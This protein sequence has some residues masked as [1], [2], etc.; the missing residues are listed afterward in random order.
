MLIPQFWAEARVQERRPTGQISVRRFGWSDESQEAAQTHAEARAREAFDRIASGAPLRRSEPKVPYNGADG[1]PIREEIIARHEDM[2]IT[3]NTYGAWCLNTPNVLFVDVD[4][5]KEVTI[6]N[7]I[8]VAVPLV[9]LSFGLAWFFGYWAI[10]GAGAA[11]ALLASYSIVLVL[12]KMGDRLHGGPE[13]HSMQKIE[14]F[15]AAH[16]A[17]QARIYRTPAGHRVLMTHRTFDPA[18]QAVADCFAALSADPD[19]VRMCKNQKCFRA[20][21]KPKPWRIGISAHMRPRPGVWPVAP[22]RLPVRQQWIEKYEAAAEGY[23]A[24]RFIKTIGTTLSDPVAEKVQII[25]DEICKA[26]QELR[27]A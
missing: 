15:M 8:M 5:E 25:H 21:I 6:G 3:R 17:W 20:R 13:R 4:F 26:N 16:P 10:L 9:I 22:E 18:E 24:C 19:Y 11:V 23:A 2:V 27:M 12:R 1:L 7:W 14:A